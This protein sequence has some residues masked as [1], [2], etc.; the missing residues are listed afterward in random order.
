MCVPSQVLRLANNSL[1]GGIPPSA[2]TAPALFLLDLHSNKLAGS[3]PTN[4]ATPALQI[5]MLEDNKL[6]GA[7][8]W[9][10]GGG[11][12][13]LCARDGC[14]MGLGRGVRAGSLPT[15]WATPALQILMLED[16]KLTGTCG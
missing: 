11:E 13:P 15:N 9:I 7:C 12:E 3:L 10:G 14:V 6:T 8:D 2:T 1:T 4:W 16:N 5:L